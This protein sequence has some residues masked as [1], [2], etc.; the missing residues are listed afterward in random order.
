MKFTILLLTV[1]PLSTLALPKDFRFPPCA[2]KCVQENLPKIG[3]EAITNPGHLCRSQP[4]LSKIER[5]FNLNCP[6]EQ[7]RLAAI[8]I[9]HSCSGIGAALKFDDRT[10]CVVS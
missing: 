8:A 3:E 10:L 5:C 1:A 6:I 4:F 7:Y 9:Q 2:A